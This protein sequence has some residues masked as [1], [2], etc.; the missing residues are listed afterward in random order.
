[1]SLA[2]RR[3]QWLAHHLPYRLDSEAEARRQGTTMVFRRLSSRESMRRCLLRLLD[4]R[5]DRRRARL[6]MAGRRTFIHQDLRPR[7]AS[8]SRA[9]PLVLEGLLEVRC[10]LLGL[11]W[12]H[13]DF[14]RRVSSKDLRGMLG[15]EG[16]EEKLRF[17]QGRRGTS[18]QIG[19][20]NLKILSQRI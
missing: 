17:V 8:S 6:G 2:S 11:G 10:H 18:Q 14:R 9:C 1:M 16:I 4:C 15:G 3:T 12:V 20:K 5:K 13:R 19:V 7:L